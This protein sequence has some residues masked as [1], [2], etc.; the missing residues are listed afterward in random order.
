MAA[1]GLN[2][3]SGAFWWFQPAQFL[4]SVLVNIGVVILVVRN[5]ANCY[6]FKTL[7]LYYLQAYPECGKRTK[8]EYQVHEP[9]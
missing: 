8:S 3:E 4:V 5:L 9:S 1:N 7:D 6:I 2:I